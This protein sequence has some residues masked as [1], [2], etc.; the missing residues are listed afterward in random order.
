MAAKIV[1]WALN[2]R[3]MVLLMSYSTADRLHAREEWKI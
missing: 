2:N 1:D 3:A